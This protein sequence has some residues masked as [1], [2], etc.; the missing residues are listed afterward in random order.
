ML[1]LLLRSLVPVLAA[2]PLAWGAGIEDPCP[3]P[4]GLPLT[5]ALALRY[6]GLLA[7]GNALDGQAARFNAACGTYHDRNSDQGKACVQ[8][9]TPL[10]NRIRDHNRRVHEFDHAL[11]AALG[12]ERAHVEARMRTTR[13]KLGAQAKLAAGFDRAAESWVDAAQEQRRRF[14]VT[15]TFG[16]LENA[17]LSIEQ[18]ADADIDLTGEEKARMADWY[19]EYGQE[20]PAKERRA[21]DAR[22]ASLHTGKD[23]GSLLGWL[24]LTGSRANEG[25]EALQDRHLR[26]TLATEAL[27]LLKVAAALSDLSP[28]VRAGM[29][30]LEVALA[31]GYYFT[32]YLAADTNLSILDQAQGLS[33]RAM[34][35]LGALYARDVKRLHALRQAERAL[36]QNTCGAEATQ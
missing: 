16:M 3:P 12:A 13:S 23:L 34:E 31:E 19:R 25:L 28:T 29:A 15:A 9:F 36:R 17:S 35:S 26:E 30:T 11:L 18:G 10:S 32:V 21:L 4:S 5:R 22:L 2:A 8:V 33:A 27:G 7:D 24:A 6:N 1:R 20:L 14:A